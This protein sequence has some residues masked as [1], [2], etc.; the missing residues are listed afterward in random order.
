MKERGSWVCIGKQVCGMG[1]GAIAAA[2]LPFTSPGNAQTAN[3][4]GSY[5]SGVANICS[6]NQDGTFTPEVWN[7]IAGAVSMTLAAQTG[8][9]QATLTGAYL[10][11]VGNYCSANTDGSFTPEVWDCMAQSMVD[12]IPFRQGV[13]TYCSYVYGF[14]TLGQRA[15]IARFSAL[16][17]DC[18]ANSQFFALPENIGFCQAPSAAMV[19]RLYPPPRSRVAQNVR[20]DRYITEQCN[21]LP[22]VQRDK[23][24]VCQPPGQPI[25]QPFA[26]QPGL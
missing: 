7:C 25:P 11:S 10:S 18:Y 5:I 4:N 22:P 24:S 26:P 2:L 6:F 9:P 17:Q 1:L 23:V 3:I 15:C 20:R 21:S 8:R 19:F 12:D 13:S 14:N 16:K